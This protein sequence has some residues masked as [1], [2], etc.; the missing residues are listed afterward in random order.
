MGVQPGRQLHSG[1]LSPRASPLAAWAHGTCVHENNCSL[2]KFKCNW[3]PCVLSGRPTFRC[4]C[5]GQGLAF[6]ASFPASSHSIPSHAPHR[7]HWRSASLPPGYLALSPEPRPPSLSHA[8]GTQAWL[9]SVLGCG[10]VF[11]GP[12]ACT[13][14]LSLLPPGNS[15]S[16][17]QVCQTLC[18][19]S[20]V[21]S[22]SRAKPDIWGYTVN[23]G[24][25]MY[26]AMVA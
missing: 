12:A 10:Y 14:T 23:T 24:L 13:H 25:N 9:R 18:F 8:P 4:Q 20:H 7:P 22:T 15:K 11:L 5:P 2:S 26:I 6:P 1:R 3:P 19:S 17:E 21:P 16:L